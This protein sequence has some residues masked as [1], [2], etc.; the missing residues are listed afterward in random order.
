[1]VAGLAGNEPPSFGK[2]LW[3]GKVYREDILLRTWSLLREGQRQNL[4][5]PDE[6]DALVQAVYEEQVEIPDSLLERS[7]KALLNGEGEAVTK[8]GQAN[9][10]IIGFPDDASWNDPGRFVLFDEDAP[11]VHRTL[12]AQTRLGE[13]S[14]VA[15]P[16]WLEDG[17]NPETLPDFDQSKSWYLR[18][19]NLS[20]KKVVIPLKKLGV[21]EGWKK[22]PLLRNCFPLVLDEQG[23]WTEDATVRLDNDLGLVYETKEAE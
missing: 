20:N 11:G 8:R 2:P 12:M 15:I 18:A 10:A 19:I 21:P 5:L 6:I 13:D 9:Q 14:V 3:W 22:S 1:L 16:L 17:F 23:C 4:A 7:D